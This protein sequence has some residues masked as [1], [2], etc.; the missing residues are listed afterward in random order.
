MATIDRSKKT[1]NK[2]R[3]ADTKRPSDTLSRNRN[4]AACSRARRCSRTA[5][6]A[7]AKNTRVVITTSGSE[8]PST[9]TW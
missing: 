2:I 3:S 7:Q 4:S 6:T 9:P 8:S 1:K 5:W